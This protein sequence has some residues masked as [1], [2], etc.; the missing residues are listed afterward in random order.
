MKKTLILLCLFFIFFFQKGI[1][2]Q[3]FPAK[4]AEWFLY[5]NS[6]FGLYSTHYKYVKDTLINSVKYAKVVH[7]NKA[8]NS[9]NPI[10]NGT[11]FSLITQIGNSI[12]RLED[13]N[14][15]SLLWKINGSAGDKY[16]VN[17]L[18]VSVDKVGIQN[19]DGKTVK[20][21]Y[22]ILTTKANGNGSCEKPI[23]LYDNIGS[24]KG[25]YLTTCDQYCILFD[26]YTPN[27]CAYKDDIIG[28]V[29]FSSVGGCNN[30][31]LD[32]NE[33]PAAEN[34]IKIY[35]NP[36]NDYI[37]LSY[38]SEKMTYSKLVISNL[39]GEVVYIQDISEK[40]DISNFLDGIYFLEV[41]KENKIMQREKIIILK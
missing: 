22:L 33:I 40:V 16:L 37:N 2:Q 9:T 28:E 25:F 6:Q 21:S 29:K 26:C 32:D 11:G 8:K 1:G 15:Q 39:Q 30:I 23:T 36:S 27:L 19:I 3:T 35:P 31:T 18:A 10:L 5:N 41:K 4:G 20:T 14:T 38:N 7:T 17:G 34:I 24:T 13:N 12:Y